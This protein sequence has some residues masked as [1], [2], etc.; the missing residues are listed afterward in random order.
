MKKKLKKKL[1]FFFLKN[2]NKIKTKLKNKFL[3]KKNWKKRGGGS[4]K[5]GHFFVT[6]TS[7]LYIDHHF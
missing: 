4:K 2:E 5:F 3:D 6:H 1:K 7:P